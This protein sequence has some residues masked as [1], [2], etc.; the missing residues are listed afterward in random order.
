MV[1]VVL[2][3]SDIP[4]DPL[5]RAVG[6]ES[7][8]SPPGGWAEETTRSR[9]VLGERVMNHTFNVASLS[10]LRWYMNWGP[11]GRPAGR[12]HSKNLLTAAEVGGAIKSLPRYHTLTY[13]KS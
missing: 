9:E 13:P 4:L 6:I 1:P 12:L 3:R 8:G 11:L 5:P 2:G 7:I 10:E